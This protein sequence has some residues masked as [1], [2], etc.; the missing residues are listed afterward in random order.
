[1]ILQFPLK[2]E[3]GKKTSDGEDGEKKE[4]SCTVGRNAN[5]CSHC[6]KQY[7]G[8]RITLQ[9]SNCTTEYPKNTKK[10]LIQRNIASLCL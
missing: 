4:P 6:G 2:E 8:S 1:M 7:G 9:S 5:W 3:D 10:K